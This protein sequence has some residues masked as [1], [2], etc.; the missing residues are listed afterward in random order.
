M[1]L[2]RY[3][4]EDDLERAPAH[5]AAQ[6]A[7][8]GGI[9]IYP[10]ET[11]YGIG[12][13]ATA[14]GA[15]RKIN[16]LKGRPE[17]EPQIVLLRWD[18]LPDYIAEHERLLPLLDAFAPGPLTLISKAIPKMLASPLTP[19]GNVAFR[20]SSSWFVE[21]LLEILGKPITSTSVNFSGKASLTKPDEIIEQFWD[22]ADGM[23]LFEN[24][25]LAGPPSTIVD[26]TRFPKELK[27]VREGA[28]SEVAIRKAIEEE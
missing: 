22:F 2:I 20:V 3:I 27:I 9:I 4:G 5:E 21:I 16:T 7:A 17:N 24:V 26:A 12:A 10:T 13:D 8:N 6:I 18:W 25:E 14:I 1:P 28:I 15:V 19:D 11:L 23:F